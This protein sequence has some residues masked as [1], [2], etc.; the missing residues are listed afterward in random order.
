MDSWVSIYWIAPL[1][2]WF[3][4]HVIKFAVMFAE[5]GGKRIDPGIF[6]KS[7]GMPSSHSAVMVSVLVV[8]GAT[9]GVGSAI[10]GLTSAL[11][12]IVIYDA[13]N[14]RRTVGE[15]GDVLKEIVSKLDLTKKFRS[16]RGHTG[17]EVAAGIAVGAAVGFVLLQIL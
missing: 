7:G 6:F 5:S 8:I 15:H 10:F 13:L 2:G 3:V 1:L 4:S 11:T 9:Q 16:S 17:V 14:V 12:A